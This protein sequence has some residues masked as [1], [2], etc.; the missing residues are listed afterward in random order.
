MV[1]FYFLIALAMTMVMGYDTGSPAS[2]LFV[3]SDPQSEMTTLETTTALKGLNLDD[4][5]TLIKHNMGLL[6]E[7]VAGNE[8]R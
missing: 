6:T 5:K 7:K 2:V 1:K 3:D 8:K 4:L